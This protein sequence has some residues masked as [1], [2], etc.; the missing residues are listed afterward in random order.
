MKKLLLIVLLLSIGYSQ[1]LIPVIETYNDGNIKSIT[2]HK[3][4]RNG[5]EKVKYEEYYYN[6]QKKKEYNYKDGILIS[7][8]HWNEDGSVNEDEHPSNEH[9]SDEH[10]SDNE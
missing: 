3:K 2:Y 5:I 1:N 9:P 6:G 7:E 10:P 8:K 4:T